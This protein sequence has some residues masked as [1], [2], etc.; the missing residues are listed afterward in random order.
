MERWSTQST[1]DINYH[2]REYIYKGGCD[3]WASLNTNNQSLSS[4]EPSCWY[5]TFNFQIVKKKKKVYI[6]DFV[7]PAI[8][9]VENI[10]IFLLAGSGQWGPLAFQTN[11]KFF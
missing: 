9:K 10:C 7:K 1:A 5:L 8:Q 6:N 3:R 11:F 2:P 4:I